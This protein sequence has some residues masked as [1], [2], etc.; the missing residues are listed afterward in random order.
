MFMF[1]HIIKD[2]I[3]HQAPCL[4]PPTNQ[5]KQQPPPRSKANPPETPVRV[6]LPPLLPQPCLN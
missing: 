4:N 5:K 1:I 6:T 2:G 3:N